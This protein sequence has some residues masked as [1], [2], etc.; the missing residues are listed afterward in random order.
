MSMCRDLYC[1]KRLFAMTSMFFW[2]NSVSFCP[3]SFC[4]T[5]PNFSVTPG[6]SW[7][8]T[9]AFLLP[10]MKRTSCLMLVLEILVD[11]QELFNF[12]FFDISGLDID[13]DYCDVEWVAL[14]MNQGHSIVFETAPKYCISESFIDNEGSSTS[15]V[16]FPTT[17]DIM[18]FWIKL[19]H[20]HPFWSTDSWD[21][22]VHSS[23]PAWPY[24]IFLDSWTWHSRFLCYIVLY[25][26][27]LYFQ[28][29][30]HPQLS[31]ISILVL[32]PK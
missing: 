8:S 23:Y 24:P 25:S 30:I 20:S 31:I 22:D 1:W 17:L 7:L 3:A 14:E 2:K 11:L 16:F 32:F 18:V 27:R 29:K 9:F 15:K 4:I 12:S 6:I 10:M 19:S 21:I 26:I 5:R 28:H 13:L